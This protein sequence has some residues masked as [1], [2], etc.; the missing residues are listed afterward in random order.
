MNNLNETELLNINAG[1]I[2]GDTVNDIEEA[3]I[4]IRDYGYDAARDFA[5]GF[6]K[7]ITSEEFH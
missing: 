5:K 2:I 1:G 4:K 7:G 6:A 3:Y